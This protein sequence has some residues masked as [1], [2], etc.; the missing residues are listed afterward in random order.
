MVDVE[1]TLLTERQAEALELRERG[2]T[3]AE[4]AERWGTTAANVS[5]VERAAERNLA[6]ARLTLEVARTLRS[7]VRFT[8]EAGT[9]F[10]ELVAEVYDRAD[11]AG[12]QVAFCRPELHGHLYGQLESVAERNR[13]DRD[14]AVGLDGEGGVR[15]SPTA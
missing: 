3:Q 11:R 4:V 2:L 10:D 14:V 7:P 6:R 12:I 15:V 8:A 1:G 9:T 5:A 13:L